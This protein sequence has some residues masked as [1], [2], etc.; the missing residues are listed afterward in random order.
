MNALAQVKDDSV[1][2]RSAGGGL[3]VH[4][5]KHG[6]LIYV[7]VESKA[8]FDNIGLPIS[9]ETDRVIVKRV[10]QGSGADHVQVIFQHWLPE[11]AGCAVDEATP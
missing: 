8:A 10:D 5:C 7:L 9:T 1:L 6:T 2:E 4:R 3:T 11:V